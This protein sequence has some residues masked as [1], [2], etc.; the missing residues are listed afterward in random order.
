MQALLPS[1]VAP[2]RKIL[3]ERA[4]IVPGLYLKVYPNA[5]TLNR[6]L[7]YSPNANN[8]SVHS[9]RPPVSQCNGVI[10]LLMIEIPENG[11]CQNLKTSRSLSAFSHKFGADSNSRKARTPIS[12]NEGWIMLKI[13][14]ISAKADRFFLNH[15]QVGFSLLRTSDTFRRCCSDYAIRP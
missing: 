9:A 1:Q 7:S 8:R 4:T 15:A 5:G 10:L 11:T 14:P 6:P 2:C 3:D 12:N 13:P